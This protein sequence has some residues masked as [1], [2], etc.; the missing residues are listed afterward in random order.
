MPRSCALSPMPPPVVPLPAV[1]DP[2]ASPAFLP[3][4]SRQRRK[5]S[6]S[7]LA[8]ACYPQYLRQ[9]GQYRRGTLLIDLPRLLA[10]YAQVTLRSRRCREMLHLLAHLAPLGWLEVRE[11]AAQDGQQRLERLSIEIAQPGI[12]RV[13]EAVLMENGQGAAAQDALYPRRRLWSWIRR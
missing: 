2:I 1:P 13:P 4:T 6:F 12:Q 7:S 9:Y 5:R 10:R 8:I 3:R 11:G